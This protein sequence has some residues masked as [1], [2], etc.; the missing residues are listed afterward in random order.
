[1]AKV[2]VQTAVEIALKVVWPAADAGSA[3]DQGHLAVVQPLL[4]DQEGRNREQ[5]DRA[6]VAGLQRAVVCQAWVAV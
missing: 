2:G 6:D 4:A 3:H 1:M 5:E